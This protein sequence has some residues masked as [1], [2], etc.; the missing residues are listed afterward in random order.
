[1]DVLTK[2]MLNNS[3]EIGRNKITSAERINYYEN[4]SYALGFL[5][6]YKKVGKY[7]KPRN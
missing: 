2:K 3:L 6:A 7:I 1:M 5:K 4:I